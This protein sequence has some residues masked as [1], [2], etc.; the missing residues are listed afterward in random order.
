MDNNDDLQLAKYLVAID[1]NATVLCGGHTKIFQDIQKALSQGYD[2]YE[3][4]PEDD[5]I[6]C[7][8]CHLA[9]V[10]R[11]DQKTIH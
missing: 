11:S 9:S 6:V 10:K 7:Q 4:D 2:M 5:P 1:N 3:L 8:A